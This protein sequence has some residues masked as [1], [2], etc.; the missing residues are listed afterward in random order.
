[1]NKTVLRCIATPPIWL[2]VSNRLSWGLSAVMMVIAV[3]FLVEQIAI[4]ENAFTKKN[5]IILI[6]MGALLI[7]ALATT[8]YLY[9]ISAYQTSNTIIDC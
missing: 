8:A 6:I 1:M 4:K 9:Y 3:I 7:I 2:L 5:K